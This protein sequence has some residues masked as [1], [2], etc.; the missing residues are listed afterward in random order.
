V[1]LDKERFEDAFVLFDLTLKLFVFLRAK[2]WLL[3]IRNEI[4]DIGFGAIGSQGRTAERAFLE[5]DDPG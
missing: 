3:G 1:R 2:T 5:A 4:I